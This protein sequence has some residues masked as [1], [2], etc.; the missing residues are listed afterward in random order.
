MG[1]N[2]ASFSGFLAA[3]AALAWRA[4][5]WAGAFSF[6]AAIAAGTSVDVPTIVV[7]AGAA[8]AGFVLDGT[9]QPVRQ[10]TVAAQVGGNVVLLT[11]K[12]GDRVKAGQLIARI[13]ERDAQA[14]V[15]RSDAALAQAEAEAR[16]ARM[17]AERMR[18]LR[19]QGF[20]SQAALDTAETQLQAAQAGMQQAQAGR[21]QAALA[22]GFASVSA[23]FDGVV[24]ATHL[25]A[26][27]LATP[28]RAIATLY[29]RAAQRIEVELPNGQW[30]VPEHRTDLGSA[31]PVSQT[32]E[33]RL[34]LAASAL[35]GVMPG[36]NVRVRFI[37]ATPAAPA[38][39][40]AAPRLPQAAVL[41]RGERTAVYVA[42]GDAFVLRAVRLGADRGSEGVDV[43]AGLKPGDRVAA[44]ALKAGLSAAR[45]APAA[46]ASK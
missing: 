42:Q 26:G 18:D 8:R 39:A 44:D 23:P 16:N 28:G 37:G 43:L 19:A 10:A 3:V 22:R 24:L 5:V 4:S 40:A 13:D 9:I 38:A 30:V 36:Q 25:D 7:Q 45:P 20:I 31:D 1:I 12:A 41:R 6:G 33:W 14:G 27:D 2:Q 46:S 17:N 21:S 15:L 29:A 34:D 35:A 32:V 11:I